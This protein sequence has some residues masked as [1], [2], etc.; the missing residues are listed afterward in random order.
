M[1]VCIGLPIWHYVGCLYVGLLW[2]AHVY[3][4][5]AYAGCSYWGLHWVCPFEA[6]IGFLFGLSIC[7]FTWDLPLFFRHGLC[8][9]CPFVGL[10]WVCPCV[11][12]MG[13][14]GLPIC[15]LASVCPFETHI[16]FIMFMGAAHMW[17]F[18]WFAHVC[19]I[20]T[21]CGLPICGF[22]LGLWTT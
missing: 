14:C 12:N 1:W 4:T 8:A 11:S 7:R 17:V 18:F 19:P 5:W 10:L 6:H 16:G 3:L 20:W 13:L 15:E 21:L 9:G 2:I 22:E